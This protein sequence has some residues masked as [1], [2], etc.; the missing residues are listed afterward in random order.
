MK[1]DTVMDRTHRKSMRYLRNAVLTVIGFSVIMV[2]WIL[3][4]LI[5]LYFKWVI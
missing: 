1:K 2:V 3:A 4:V 5:H